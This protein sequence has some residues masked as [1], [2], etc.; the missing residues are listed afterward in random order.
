MPINRASRGVRC[1]F[2]NSRIFKRAFL[3]HLM[4]FHQMKKA[5]AEAIRARM[6]Q[7][8]FVKGEQHSPAKIVL[9]PGEHPAAVYAVRS[10]K[11][12]ELPQ[13]LASLKKDELIAL[14]AKMEAEANGLTV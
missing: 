9:V 3:T 7:E 13:N 10:A 12:A 5:D 6:R 2:C 1:C 8:P 4:E 14:L 11:P